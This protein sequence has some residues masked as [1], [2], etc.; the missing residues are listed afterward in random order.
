MPVTGWNLHA[1]CTVNLGGDRLGLAPGPVNVKRG[2]AKVK[3][4][5]KADGYLA[6]DV[7][8]TPTENTTI[9]I[10]LTRIPGARPAHPTQKQPGEIENP[11]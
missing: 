11:F 7:D 3:L 10:S 2:G 9:S 8:V 4:N 5:L 1:P 6:A